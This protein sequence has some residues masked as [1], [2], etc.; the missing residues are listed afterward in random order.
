[1]KE[2]TRFPDTNM[3]IQA[4]FEGEGVVLARSAHVW[5]DLQTG[6]LERLFDITCPSDVSVDLVCRPER[7]ETPAFVAFRDWLL[8]EARK[9]QEEFDAAEGV[10]TAPT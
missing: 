5:E 6:R 7:A 9:S 4:A 3:A 2:G 1:L 10:T 8:D